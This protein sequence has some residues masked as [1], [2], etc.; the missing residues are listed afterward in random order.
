MCAACFRSSGRLSLV[1]LCMALWLCSGL[2][3]AQTSA[4]PLQDTGP[5]PAPTTPTDEFVSLILRPLVVQALSSSEAS[6]R[7]LSAFQQQIE[8]DRLAREK[9][10]SERQSEQQ[11]S[12]RAYSTL[13][14]RAAALQSFSDALLSR[15]TDFSGSEEQRQAQALAALDDIQADARRLEGART[16]WRNIAIVTSAVAVTLI[17]KS[18]VKG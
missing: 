13:S 10:Q 8:S 5:V 15:L 2:A 4:P 3:V 18:V 11:D 16:F 6:D 14:A 12:A 17:V 1:S 9:E 7:T